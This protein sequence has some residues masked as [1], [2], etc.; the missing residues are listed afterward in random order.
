MLPSVLALAS[1]SV[2]KAFCRR[3][4]ASIFSLAGGLWLPVQLQAHAVGHG[5]DQHVAVELPGVDAFLAG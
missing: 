4:A 5:Q 1:P 2:A 3:R